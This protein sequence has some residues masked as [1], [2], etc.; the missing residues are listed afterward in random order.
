MFP[1]LPRDLFDTSITKQTISGM[2]VLVKMP[3]LCSHSPSLSDSPPPPLPKLD[4]LW[5]GV[6]V[7]WTSSERTK[8]AREKR[9]SRNATRNFRK[10]KK[11]HK[12]KY[13]YEWLEFLFHQPIGRVCLRFGSNHQLLT[14]VN[15]QRPSIT[16]RPTPIRTVQLWWC[17]RHAVAIPKF[18]QVRC[19]LENELAHR[20]NAVTKNTLKRHLL[21]HQ[22]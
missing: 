12:K 15:A 14:V 11:H 4:C 17:H 18:K 1:M 9:C 21:L 3:I 7:F 19:F 20:K 16:A 2:H 22:V 10:Q 8:N 5:E 6:T 13:F